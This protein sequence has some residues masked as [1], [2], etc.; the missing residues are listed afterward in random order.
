MPPPPPEPP[1][2]KPPGKKPKK[3]KKIVDVRIVI[4]YKCY[5]FNTSNTI[6][7]RAKPAIDEILR[8]IQGG[9]FQ[10]G[11]MIGTEVDLAQRHN[12]SRMTVRRAL[13]D[14]VIQK[15]IERRPGKGVFVHHRLAIRQVFEIV[16]PN[17]GNPWVQ[18]IMGAQEFGQAHGVKIQ[19]YNAQGGLD[20]DVDVVRNLPRTAPSGAIIGP[21]PRAK[22]ERVLGDLENAHYPF[23]L[24]GQRLASLRSPTVTSDDYA[25]G[26]SIGRRLVELG[27]RRIGFIGDMSS[28]SVATRLQGLRDAMNDADVPFDRTLAMNLKTETVWDDFSAD[29][30]RCTRELMERPNPP[31]A[32]HYEWDGL[33]ADGYCVLKS[34]GLRIPEDISVVGYHDD[35][36]CQWLQPSLATVRAFLSRHGRMAVEMLLQLIQGPYAK[37]ESQALPVEWVERDSV[38]EVKAS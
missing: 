19:V 37:V 9:E 27:H 7:G 28:A 13:N 20:A 31:T 10:P 23:V 5:M 34:M 4:C 6:L 26:Y 33:A 3:T 22:F 15:V 29:N 16:V 35:P 38:A 24:V 1:P 36:I 11:Q 25:G 32:L 8:Q 21:L 2:E 12:I 17:F 18:M 30:E 14:L